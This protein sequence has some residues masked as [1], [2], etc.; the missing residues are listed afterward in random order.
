[1][2][3]SGD[4]INVV[5][6]G[7]AAKNKGYGLLPDAI[8][9][10][11]KAR[12]DLR[13][14]IHG[15]VAHTGFPEAKSIMEALPRLGNNVRTSTDTLSAEDYI[16]WLSDA[17]IAMLPYDTY[18]YRTQGSAVFDEAVG[19]GIPV[20]APTACDFA[21]SAISEGRAVGIEEVTAEGLANAVEIAAT[22][23]EQLTDRAARYSANQDID[24]SLRDTIGKA[25]AIAERRLSW[26]DSSSKRLRRLFKRVS[27]W[28]RSQSL[29]ST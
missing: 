8:C 15:T 17:D 2:R 26:F 24:T 1:V 14:S 19:L 18:V 20:V 7:N 5:C 13:F 25:V 22:R 12:N 21:K 28:P 3:R 16:A 10:L 4:P 27:V 29:H 11:N 9:R 23:I 6:V